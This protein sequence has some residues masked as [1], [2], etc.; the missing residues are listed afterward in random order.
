MSCSAH[1]NN[2]VAILKELYEKLVDHGIIPYY[3]HQLDRVQG[4][5]H[6]EVSEDEGRE[7]I[8]QLTSA[9][10]GY[11]VPKYVREEAGMTAKTGLS[12]ATACV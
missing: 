8:A 12:I 3:L 7:L 9:M 5:A 4:A 11:A 1:I 2:Q 10:S 6:F